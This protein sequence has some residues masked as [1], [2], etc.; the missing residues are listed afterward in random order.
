M[1]SRGEVE[2]I[3]SCIAKP[4][5]LLRNLRVRRCNRP[6]PSNSAHAELAFTRGTEEAS[7][8]QGIAG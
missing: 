7:A 4:Q 5:L 8:I 2:G 6:R 3:V 1:I